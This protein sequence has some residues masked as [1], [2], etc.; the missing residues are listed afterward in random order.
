MFNGYDVYIDDM[1]LPI[2]PPAITITVGS[3]NKTVNLINEGDINVL[4]SPSLTTVSFEARFPMRQY[5][6]S[7]ATGDFQ[8]YGDK[9]K[10]LKEEK[11]SFSFIVVRETPDGK[12]LWDT[13]ITCSLE[14]YELKEDAENGDDVI[15][16]FELKQYKH[17]Q[18]K[19]VKIVNNKVPPPN[20]NPARPTN[21]PA[22]SSPQNQSYT[23]KSGDTLW[24]IAQSFYKNGSQYTKIYNANK[25][26]IEADAK[27]HG[28]ASSSNGHWIWA[29]LKLTIP[30]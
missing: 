24:G 12:S 25:A 18:T 13:N 17:Y 19:I 14:S 8:T 7:K 21:P 26:A 15:I 20:K 10:N 9:L 30:K 6:Y 4:K 16:T 22:Q 1:L 3:N 29:G 5:P 23:V 28:K 27:K 11:K 2:T